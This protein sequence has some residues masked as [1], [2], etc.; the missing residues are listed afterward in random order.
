LLSLIE[1]LDWPVTKASYVAAI[2]YPQDPDFPLDA[3]IL[4]RVPRELPGRM[5]R[6][7][8]DVRRLDV[9]EPRDEGQ[10][11]VGWPSGRAVAVTQHTYE[12]SEDEA[13]AELVERRELIA[14]VARKFK[15]SVDEAA[16]AV[17]RVDALADQVMARHG[18]TRDAAIIELIRFGG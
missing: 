7:L 12:C 10:R 5:P 17:T 14:R 4:A 18:L 1:R 3:E 11:P 9:T 8:R 16:V 6:S 13:V 15:L 2:F